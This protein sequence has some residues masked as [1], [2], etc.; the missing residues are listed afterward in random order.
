LETVC[1]L[2]R[3]RNKQV[4]MR[5]K[6]VKNWDPIQYCNS[7]DVYEI[8]MRRTVLQNI[9]FKFICRLVYTLHFKAKLRQKFQ[10]FKILKNIM[11]DL[12]PVT[13]GKSKGKVVPVLK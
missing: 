9:T 4:T 8:N 3:D 10:I 12:H 6:T 1:I 7:K 11:E 5:H 2:I 13:K